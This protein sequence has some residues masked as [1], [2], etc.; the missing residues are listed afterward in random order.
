MGDDLYKS[1]FSHS[2]GRAVAWLLYL[3]SIGCKVA[4][5]YRQGRFG[6]MQRF[7]FEQFEVA[8][9]AMPYCH[10]PIFDEVRCLDTTTL[11]RRPIDGPIALVQGLKPHP[12]KLELQEVD[13]ESKSWQK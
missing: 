2:N 13:A 11:L 4:L 9:A 3:Y 7:A 12:Q 8:I 5:D 10:L 6:A 1:E